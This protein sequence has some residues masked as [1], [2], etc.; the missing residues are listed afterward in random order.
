MKR[1]ELTYGFPGIT[2]TEDCPPGF[3]R[4]SGTLRLGHGQAEF[5][6][7]S[8][9]LRGWTTHR[10]FGRGIRPVGAGQ[11]VGDVVVVSLGFGPLRISA[12]CRIVWR[13]DEP[14][15]TGFAYGTLPGHPECGEESFVLRLAETGAV[16]FTVTAVSKPVSWY[17]RLAGP[18]GRGLQWAALQAYLRALRA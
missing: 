3:R 16:E 5:E 2:R 18:V 10:G 15:S 6:R 17:A 7:A 14:R 13:V 4:M 8:R 9:A 1:D 12:P 11:E